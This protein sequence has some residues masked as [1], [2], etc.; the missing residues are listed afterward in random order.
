M[1]LPLSAAIAGVLMSGCQKALF[2]PDE[3]RSPYDRYDAIRS[4]RPAAYQEDEF[5]QKKPNLRGR[6]LENE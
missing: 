3:E 4:Q 1:L 5:G 2:A 6:L